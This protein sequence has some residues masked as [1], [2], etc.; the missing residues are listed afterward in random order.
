[1]DQWQVSPSG[2]R[3]ATKRLQQL[4]KALTGRAIE[5]RRNDDMGITTARMG[6]T[7]HRALK[8]RGWCDFDYLCFVMFWVEWLILGIYLIRLCIKIW[9]GHDIL[10]GQTLFAA[11]NERFF[12]TERWRRRKRSKWQIFSTQWR[13]ALLILARRGGN[14]TL[15]KFHM[16]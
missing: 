12:S 7:D 9:H 10:L 14:S 3:A 6:K 2:E 15:P 13:R 16:I 5:E 4:A 8:S 11:W 1:M